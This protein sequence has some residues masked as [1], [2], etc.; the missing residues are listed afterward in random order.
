MFTSCL[1][2][3]VAVLATLLVGAGVARAQGGFEELHTFGPPGPV[4]PQAPLLKASDGNFYGTTR[5]GGAPDEGTVFRIAPDGTFTV[6]H[7]FVPGEGGPTQ[8]PLVE[9]NG[10]IYGMTDSSVFK[11]TFDGAVTLL[12]Q[13]GGHALIRASNGN[14]YGTTQ[15]G[16]VFRMSPAETFGTLGSFGSG[17]LPLQALAEASDGTLYVSTDGYRVFSITTGDIR[18]LLHEFNRPVEGGFISSL[19]AAA[20]GNI[21]GTAT[22]DGPGN[23]GTFFRMTPAGAITVLHAFTNGSDGAHP[24]AV[25]QAADGMLY[26][27]TEFGTV[28]RAT[29]DGAVTTLHVFAGGAEGSVP[30]AGLIQDT[31]GNFYG[32]TSQPVG[33]VFRMTAQGVLT[34]LHTFSWNEDGASP[35]GPLV[36]GSDGSLYGVTPLG[37]T[38]GVGTLFKSTTDGSFHVLHTFAGARDGAEPTTVISGLDDFL[39]GM[40]RYGGGGTGTVFRSTGDG[41][42]TNLHEF[43]SP[44]QAAAALSQ[45]PDGTLYG[46]SN[47][48]F[49]RLTLDGTF[50]SLGGPHARFVRARDG[51]FY[52][53]DA[54]LFPP[55]GFITRIAPDGTGT[56]VFETHEVC[57]PIYGPKGLKIG[58][59]C[60][61]TNGQPP[62]GIFDGIDGQVY[63]MRSNTIERLETDGSLTGIAAFPKVPFS[64]FQ[65]PDE[66]FIVAAGD[67]VWRVPPDGAPI[68]LH[69]FPSDRDGAV[70][71]T[72]ARDGHIYGMTRYGGAFGRGSIFRLSMDALPPVVTATISPA[73]GTSGWNREPVTVHLAATDEFSGVQRIVYA[74]SGAQPIALTSIAGGQV[75]IPIAAEGTTTL[76]FLAVDGANNV[77]V[78]EQITV[79][80]DQTAPVMQCSVTPNVLWPPNNQLVNVASSVDVADPLSG[81]AGFELVLVTSNDPSTTSTD[82]VGWTIGSPSLSGQLRAKRRGANLDRLY[83]LQY[84]AFDQVGNMA[85][86]SIPVVV[87]HDQRGR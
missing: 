69:T 12:T 30:F 73:P 84:R 13:M 74:A 40:T 20:D 11:M 3:S 68:P 80:I 83:T 52:A 28:F 47:M 49:F 9:A 4:R 1:L 67:V 87:P 85:H 38:A 59:N 42:L 79:R 63:V 45:A 66:G 76:T 53:I 71:V 32:T 17:N 18:T 27:T 46:T 86:C 64:A 62:V 5:A 29:T 44:D 65:A 37:G 70:G 26:G 16:L 61:M 35:T 50:T 6:I 10:V 77:S 7:E 34:V 82:I 2:R 22:S 78:P 72:L 25:M 14:L 54:I 24:I 21:Y 19:I 55:A 51:Y 15:G 75:N 31:D 56:I 33:A 39:Y 58:E 48:S 23:F 57:T 8:A 36:E 43:A 81:P 41:D 60:H